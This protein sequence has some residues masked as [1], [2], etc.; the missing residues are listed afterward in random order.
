MGTVPSK[1]ADLLIQRG[2]VAQGDRVLLP[3]SLVTGCIASAP[4]TFT[5]HGRDPT[6]S[7][8]IGQD[9][10]YFGTGGAAVQVLDL[11]TER[12]RPATLHDLHDFT[13]LQDRLTN[14]AW[15]TRCCIPTDIEDAYVQE[16]NV[17][18]SL[19]RNTTKPVAMSFTLPEYVPPIVDM[20]RIAGDFDAAP[21]MFAHISPVISPLRYGEDAVDVTFACL[22]AGMPV[23][24]ITA[25]QSGATGPAPLASFLVHSLAETLASLV[26]VQVIKPGHPMCFANWPFV[27]DLRTGAFTGGGG[28]TALMN[29]AS[30]QLT[31]WLG[32]PS[33]VASS[34]TD[35]KVPDAQYGAEKG[36]TA[37]AAALGGGNMIAESAGMMAALLGA[38][39]EAFVL[40]DEMIGHVYRMLRGVE[41]SAE[42]LDLGP[43]KSAVLGEGHFLGGPDTMAAMERD[44]FYP[45]LAD[46]ETPRAWEEAGARDAWARAK[47]AAQAILADHQPRYL[48]DA[49]EA[50][51]AKAFPLKL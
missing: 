13:R 26:M 49:Q 48:S 35:A 33:G 7:I 2:A 1:L 32:L 23:S 46:R 11:A 41:V 45:K 30:A 51:I 47:E 27:I 39:F 37:L 16:V 38:S 22:E 8:E 6:R 24:C 17:A 4:K 15:F 40:D 50:A 12:Y 29:A 25:A 44:Y 19:L 31:N 9:R 34:M 43:I 21:F 20:L 3:E 36:M 18:H 14:V 42:T 5:L 10:V 28:E